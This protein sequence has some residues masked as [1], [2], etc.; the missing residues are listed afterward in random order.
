[1]WGFKTRGIGPTEPR[2]QNGNKPDGE[3]TNSPGRDVIGGDLAVTAFADISF[4]LPIRWL[5][6]NGVHGH[7]FAGAGNLA[8]LTENEFRNFT[9]K[10]FVESAR[11]SVGAGIVVPTK[12]FRLEVCY[13]IRLVY[14]TESSISTLLGF[15]LEVQ[16]TLWYRDIMYELMLGVRG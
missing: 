11:S 14:I 4:D 3:N 15:Q 2:R 10:K 16:L 9:V 6:E 1:M 12:F 8:K 7:V 13:H 5:R